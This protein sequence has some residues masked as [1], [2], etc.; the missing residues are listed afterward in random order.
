VRNLPQGYALA[1]TD[2]SNRLFPV[3]IRPRTTVHSG[4][5]Y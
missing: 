5:D 1:S 2:K 3:R 4:T